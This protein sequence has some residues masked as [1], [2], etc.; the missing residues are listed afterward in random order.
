M[1]GLGF[2]GGGFGLSGW[3]LPGEEAFF[4]WVAVEERCEGT[5]F[6]GRASFACAGFAVGE[7]EPRLSMGV[8]FFV[9]FLVG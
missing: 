3:E 9:G 2:F 5:A 1:L 4:A 6:F 7:Q 8:G